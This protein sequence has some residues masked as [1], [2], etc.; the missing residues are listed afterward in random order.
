MESSGQ[1]QFKSKYHILVWIALLALAL[2]GMVEYGYYLQN[3]PPFKW[4][5]Y[6]GLIPFS[7][8]NVCSFSFL[9]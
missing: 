7:S 2:I 4:Q 3:R 9:S 1:K 8:W 6:L 5:I